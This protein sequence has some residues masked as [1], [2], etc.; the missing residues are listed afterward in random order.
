M[1][2]SGKTVFGG[3]VRFLDAAEGATT[4]HSV[5]KVPADTH[6]A[7]LDAGRKFLAASVTLHDQCGHVGLDRSVP[8]GRLL[9]LCPTKKATKAGYGPEVGRRLFA[10]HPNVELYPKST[11][12]SAGPPRSPIKVRRQVQ[13]FSRPVR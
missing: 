6:L 4:D 8:V 5:T 1:R 11:D 9:Y 3:E 10:L 7:H 13:L 2:R 12:D